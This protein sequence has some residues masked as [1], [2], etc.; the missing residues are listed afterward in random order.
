MKKS[1]Y[2]LI[3]GRK[4]IVGGTMDGHKI[5]KTATIP[6]VLMIIGLKHYTQNLVVSIVAGIGIYFAVYFID[7]HIKKR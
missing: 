2:I 6:I 5:F 4:G 1:T 3:F 7:R